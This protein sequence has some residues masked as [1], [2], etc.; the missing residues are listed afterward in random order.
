MEGNLL[1]K[2][3]RDEES[4]NILA[5]AAENDIVDKFLIVTIMIFFFFF[6]YFF[7]F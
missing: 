4:V 3:T 6:L 2:F 5:D 1:S 7:F